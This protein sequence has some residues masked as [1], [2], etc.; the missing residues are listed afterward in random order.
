MQSLDKFGAVRAKFEDSV[1]F[2]TVYIAEAHPVEEGYFLDKIYDLKVHQSMQERI[3]AARLLK[4]EAGKNLTGCPIAV[5]QFDNKA[6]VAFAALPER[7]F[8]ILD[9]IVVY[10][11]R[12]GP[13][14]YNLDELEQFLESKKTK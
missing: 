1:D 13:F 8:V 6:Q 12:L 10:V 2:L 14:G 9:G 7:L 3:D 11:G 5:D 4:E